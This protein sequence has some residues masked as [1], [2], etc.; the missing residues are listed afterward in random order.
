MIFGLALAVFGLGASV[1]SAYGY[2]AATGGTL[3]TYQVGA[4]IYNVHTFTGSGTFTVTTGGTV[5]YLVIAGGGGGGSGTG[6]GGGAGGFLESTATVTGGSTAYTITVGTGG[7]GGTANNAGSAGWGSTGNPSSFDVFATATGG[8]GGAPNS[9]TLSPANGNPGGSGG[10]GS[11]GTPGVASTGGAAT[12]GQGNAGGACLAWGGPYVGGGGGGAGAVGVAGNKQNPGAAGGAGKPSSITGTSTTYAAGGGG[13]AFNSPG[14]AGGLGGLTGHGGNGSGGATA[15]AANT[16]SGGGGQGGNKTG[17]GAGG[18]GIVIISYASG[19]SP[20]PTSTSATLAVSENTV[21]ALAT[22]NFGYADPNSSPLAAVQITTL[23]ALG[24]LKLSGT[25]VTLNQIVAVADINSGNLTYQSALPTYGT[26]AAYTTVGIKVENATSLWSAAAVM[27][28]NVTPA[29]IVQDPSFETPGASQAGNWASFVSP[30]W[31]SG[32]SL[33]SQLKVGPGFD[34]TFS[35]AADGNWVALINND[36]CPIATPVY[37]NLSYSVSA[38][39]TLSVTFAYGRD[40]GTPGQGVAYFDVGG[41]KYTQGFDASALSAGQWGSASMTKTITNSG[42]L[43]LGFYGNSGH[44][45]NVWVDKVSDVS[46]TP[47]VT[48][49]TVTYNANSASSGTAPTDS[50]S[51]YNSGATVTVLGNTGTLARTGYTFGGWNTANDGSGT[52]YA[53]TGSPTFSIANNVTLYAEWTGTVTY[54]A[55]SASSGSVPTDATAYKQSQSAT[56]ASNSGTLA[57]TGYTFAGWNTATNGS[58]TSYTAGSGSIPMS[59]GNVTVYA[60]WTGTVTYNANNATSGMVPTDATAYTQNQSATAAANSGALVRT[61]YTFSGW[62]TAADGTGTSYTAGSGSIPMAGGNVTLYAKWT[63]ATTYSV[64]YLPNSPSSGTAPTD[65]SSPYT[66]GATVTVLA[67]TGTLART[68]YTFGGWNTATDGSGTHYAATGSATFSMPVND[69]T[70]YAEW[71]ATVT[72]NANSASTGSVPTDA[73]AYTQNQSATAANN[74]GTLAKSGYTFAGWN[75]A[76]DGTGTSYAAGSGSIAMAGGNVTLYA[77]WTPAP[78]ITLA[79]TLGAV[80]TTYGTASAT[81]TSFH[82]SGSALTGNL[83]VAPPSGYE[84]SL[85]SGSDYTTSLSITASGT[86]SS[87]QV[88]VR[89]AATAGVAGSPYSG[90]ITVSGGGASSQTIA[91]ASS[92]VAKADATVVVTPYTVDYD[93]SPHTATVASITGVNGETGATVGTVTLDT[94]HTNAGTYST[95]SWHLAG[96]ANYNNIGTTTTSITVTNGGF[97]DPT[98]HNPNNGTN[99]DWTAGGWAFVGAPWT[100]STANYSRL[101]SAALVGTA[102]PG[103]WIMNLNDS[104]GWVKQDLGTTVHAGDTLAVTFHVMSDTAPGQITA[105]FTVGS[106][107]Y[108]QTFSNPQNKGTFASYTLTKTVGAG[109]SGNLSVKFTQASGRLWLDNISNVSWTYGSN[110]Q[111]ITDTINKVTPTATLAV[112]NSPVTYDGTPKAATVGVTT[113]SVPGLAQNILTGGAATKT[114][115]GTYE[116]TADFVP[117]DTTNYNTLTALSAGNFIIVTPYNAWANGTFANGASLS[118]KTPAGNQDSDTLTNLQEYAFGTDPTD[119]SSGPGAISYVAGGAVTT[120]GSPVA[121]NLAVGEGVDYRAVFGRRKDH[122][123]AGLTYTVQFSVDNSQWVNSTDTPTVLTGAGALNPSEIE[124]V[125]VP[126]PLFIP[127]T[128]N[129][130]PGF[131]KPTFFRVGVTSSN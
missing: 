110:P 32:G 107:D 54:N 20:N 29:I 104:G 114:A 112:N 94:T 75:T 46:Y 96:T 69:E 15:G 129:D 78:T 116:V 44:G 50:S 126:Y 21:T 24:T 22:G 92:T 124:A 123:T 60:M 45:I 103:P 97:E 95:D 122:G 79:D 47:G 17:A 121:A 83:T 120:P 14:G 111:T 56:A 36:D 23:P 106:T 19:T 25:A 105:T 41:T 6:G 42:N 8:G 115:A 58:G 128:R 35:N 43:T 130:I 81:P 49:Y 100:A 117:T 27:T 118:D 48:T 16:G 68:G 34:S 76:N 131:E 88:F 59:S 73:T 119:G 5:N 89:L 74:S 2:V 65:S 84:V 98:P 10:G 127:Y 90:T 63:A 77:K 31:S 108:S 113:S 99:A 57:R 51:P 39:A 70:L 71:T 26:G 40:S 82:V 64:T 80:N 86:L 53:A 13:G 85:S 109:V 91:T 4:T 52:H 67:N 33:Y 37:Q 101:S 55:N 66:S 61:S 87:T 3:T 1:P 12:S 7:A 18:S 30:P 93:G 38:G 72:Y 11:W 9:T 28:V 62:N 102:Q 125:S